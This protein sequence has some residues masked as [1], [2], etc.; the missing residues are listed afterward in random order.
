MTKTQFP[1]TNDCNQVRERPPRARVR[2]RWSSVPDP[3]S[4]VPSLLSFRRAGLIAFA[5]AVV[6]A[7]RAP[8]APLSLDDAIRMALQNNQRVKVSAFS[9]QISRAN[10]LAAYGAFE[11]ALTFR[12]SYAENETAGPISPFTNR[13]LT[14]TDNY[15]LSLDGLAPWGMTYS[16]GGTATNSRGTF[17][18]FSDNYV[19]FGGISVTQPLL[20]GFGFGATLANLRVA[21]ANRGISDWEHRRTVIDTVTNVILVYNS[22]QQARDTAKIAH[23]SRDLTAQLVTDNERKLAVG[24]TSDAEVTQ[25]RAQLASREESVLFAE[26]QVRDTEN[27]L[28]LLLGES[29]FPLDGPSLD[30]VE[31]APSANVA[32]D[33]AADLKKAYAL[34]PDYQ[35]ARLG[36]VIDRANQTL[37]QNQL[38][39][40]VDFVGSYGY[41]GLDPDF[42]TAR[43]QVRNEDARSYSA[44]VVV[45]LPL[46]FTEGRGRA[47]AA[48]LALR[49]SEVDLTRLEADIAIAV[50]T[51]AGQIETAQQR[52]AASR[53]AYDLAQQALSNEEKRFKAGT[54]TTFLVLNQQQSLST[55]QNAYARA[56]ADQRRALANYERELGTTLATHGIVVE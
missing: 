27:Q 8:A 4:L 13:P 33:V 52:V 11:P 48:R 7:P 14:Q 45:R 51:A 35:A 43:N 26:R 44:G 40:R 29:N 10:L 38:L 42:R 50:T 56:L 18:A 28:R 32:L 24:S 37:A 12:R 6:F 30:T 1:M 19:T 15:S 5:L 25:A 34:R 54:S 20:R 23:Q 55:A 17:N 31:L 41:N 16:I 46:G 9:P 47:R 53:T 2:S 39:P 49:Q 22:L 3:W 21:K 36:I